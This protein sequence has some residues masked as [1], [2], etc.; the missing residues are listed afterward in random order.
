LR[1]RKEQKEVL[2]LI[3]LPSHPLR[4]LQKTGLTAHVVFHNSSSLDLALASTRKPRSWPIS[5]ETSGLSHYQSLYDFLRPPLDSLKAHSDSS[6]ELYEYE[7]AKR[8][9]ILKSR[10]GEANVDDDGFTLATACGQTLAEASVWRVTVPTIRRDHGDRNL[11]RRRKVSKLFTRQRNSAQVK[12]YF[13]HS[14]TVST[15]LIANH[16]QL[17]ELMEL[18][19]KWEE[20]KAKVTVEKLKTS[21]RFKP[22]RI[23]YFAFPRTSY[24]PHF[25]Y[26]AQKNTQ[27]SNS[28]HRCIILVRCFTLLSSFETYSWPIP[29]STAGHESN[30]DV[31]A[32]K[33]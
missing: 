8:K 7:L 9:Q 2:T 12:F 32:R 27:L 23:A 5:S 10:K 21:R 4:R 17:L 24:I 33:I 1:T 19:R 20:D 16:R 26:T 13:L 29:H 22:Y 31:A 6:I 3:P 30:S 28:R 18:K 11:K 15:Q 25:D 14:M